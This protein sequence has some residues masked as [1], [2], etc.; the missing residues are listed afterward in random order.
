LS[1]LQINRKILIKAIVTEDF[2][3]NFASQ[4]KHI[5]S[6]ID[7][8][9]EKIKA[10]ESRLLISGNI[11]SAE[12][13]NFRTR[14]NKERESQEVAKQE[15]EEKMKEIDKL[16]IGTVY[17]YTTLDSTVEVKEGDNLFEKINHG[18]VLIRDGI[19]VSIKD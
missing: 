14:L 3:S 16:E 2:K 12:L 1:A 7:A 9:I 4:L 17:P 13:S 8:N 10:E 11:G 5:K 18:E 15:V 19:I 6:E